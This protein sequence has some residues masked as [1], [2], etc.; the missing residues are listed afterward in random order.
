MPIHFTEATIPRI[1]QLGGGEWHISKLTEV[2][3]LFGRNG[4]G[5]SVMLRAWRDQSHENIHYVTPERTGE[6]DFQPEIG[7]W[8]VSK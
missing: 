6:M 2:T 8:P 4:S 5:K 3:V 7:N 1:A